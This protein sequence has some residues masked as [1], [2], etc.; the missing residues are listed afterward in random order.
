VTLETHLIDEGSLSF[1][2]RRAEAVRLKIP[3]LIQRLD[4]EDH[5]SRSTD[6]GGASSLHILTPA[7]H[8]SSHRIQND[9]GHSWSSP[10]RGL[11][12]ALV[13]QLEQ[14]KGEYFKGSP[15][16]DFKVLFQR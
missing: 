2:H 15:S 12:V 16:R 4:G 1:P 3:L 10:R 6:E 14:V 9:P 13:V 5:S 7:G 11:L 8:S